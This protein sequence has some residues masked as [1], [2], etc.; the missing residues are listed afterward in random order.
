MA[1]CR[2]S[3]AIVIR[4]RVPNVNSHLQ[5]RCYNIAPWLSGSALSVRY[6]ARLTD[7]DEIQVRQ[8][9]ACFVFA[10]HEVIST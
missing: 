5:P 6:P 4:T 10:S 8:L 3:D 9:L 2:A 7:C 1:T